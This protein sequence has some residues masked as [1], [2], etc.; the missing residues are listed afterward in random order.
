MS[1]VPVLP[2][3]FSVDVAPMPPATGRTPDTRATSQAAADAVQPTA[4][5]LRAQLL[6]AIRRMGGRGL[7][8]EEAQTLLGMSGNTE[9]PR[10][11]EL[12]QAGL[13]RPAGVRETASGRRA[14]VWIAVEA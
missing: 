9:R 13:I 5:S 7:T 3:L 14:V 12:E 4:A 8:D 2:G 6:A 1:A 10:R 11:R